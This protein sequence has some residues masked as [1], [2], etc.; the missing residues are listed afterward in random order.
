MRLNSPIPWAAVLGAALP[1]TSDPAQA[2]AACGCGDPTLTVMGAEKPFAGRLRGALTLTHRSDDVGTV[3][4]S[5]IRAV[6]ER[7]EASVVYAPSD[8]LLLSATL[9]VLDRAL[10]YVSL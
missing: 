9:P 6:E 10:H 2:C 4:L 7:L 3:Q 8:W 1:L 5:Q